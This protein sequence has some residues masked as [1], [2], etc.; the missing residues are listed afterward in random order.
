MQAQT[1]NKRRILHQC[2][3]MTIA[4]LVASSHLVKLWATDGIYLSPDGGTYEKDQVVTIT[5]SAAPAYIYPYGEQCCGGGQNGT[6]EFFDIEY[7]G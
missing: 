6:Y 3:I 4:L 5:A 2:G 1:S 7:T